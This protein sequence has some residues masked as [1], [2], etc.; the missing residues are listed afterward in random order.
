MRSCAARIESSIQEVQ[1]I[2]D[3]LAYSQDK[4]VLDSLG[5]E[6]T[7][8]SSSEGSDEETDYSDCE[9]LRDSSETMPDHSILSQALR[10]S[11]FNWFEFHENVECMMEHS[12][13]NDVSKTLEEFFLQIPHMGLSQ[14]ETE[15]TVLSHRVFEAAASHMSRENCYEYKR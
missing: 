8:S 13:S 4:A 11:N 10:E 12:D 5:I 3:M 1:E 2:F 7:S 14:S 6:S 9:S 15:C